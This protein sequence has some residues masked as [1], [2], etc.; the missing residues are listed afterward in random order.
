ML[1]SSSP[2]VTVVVRDRQS[3]VGCQRSCQQVRDPDRSVRPGTDQHTASVE[4][5]R[6]V[7]VVGEHVLVGFAPVGADLLVLLGFPAL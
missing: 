4:R 1:C 7:P 5:T 2:E 6:P 3:V